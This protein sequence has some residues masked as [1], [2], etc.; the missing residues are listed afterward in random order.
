MDLQRKHSAW[1]SIN[2][3]LPRAELLSLM[4]RHKYGING[5]LDEHF[6]IAVAELVKS[7]SIVFVPNGGGQKEIVGAPELIYDGVDDAVAKIIAV[8]SEENA[9]Q[10]ALE[11]MAH[12]GDIFSIEAFCNK[13]RRTVQDFLQPV[14]R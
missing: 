14:A 3:G 5:A 2:G 1:I 11:K 10:I 6:G 9:Q 13:M 12:Q 8:V 4:N 7:G